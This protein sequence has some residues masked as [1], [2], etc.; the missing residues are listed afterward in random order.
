MHCVAFWVLTFAQVLRIVECE[1][2]LMK[3]IWFFFFLTALIAL[4]GGSMGSTA[5]S[6][7]SL[8]LVPAQPNM[9]QVAR[10]MSDAGKSMMM[11]YSPDAPADSPFLHIWDGARWLPVSVERFS[12]G[13]FLANKAS[14]L[15]VVGDETERTAVLIERSM[16]WCPEVLHMQTGNV[17]ELINQ[18]GKVYGFSRADWEWIAQRYQLKMEDLTK[19]LPR[20]SWYDTNTPADVP[21]TDPPW[22]RKST[23][24]VVVPPPTTSLTPLEADIPQ[25]YNL[26][27]EQ[28]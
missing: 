5:P 12:T 16:G 27:M 13:S 25:S 6:G 4:P 28:Q 10:D 17:T 11:T 21:V 1:V 22:K 8:L 23:R 9:V 7:V 14:R 15:V 2:M 26:E 3:C 20:D 24:N 18:L 19:D